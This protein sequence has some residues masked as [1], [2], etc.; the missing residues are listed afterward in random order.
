MKTFLEPLA[1]IVKVW[2]LFVHLQNE[3]IQKIEHSQC[4]LRTSNNDDVVDDSV[5]A[6]ILLLFYIF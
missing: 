3:V 6:Y 1:R 4:F 5:V 2:W